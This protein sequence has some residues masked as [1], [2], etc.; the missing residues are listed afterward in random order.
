MWTCDLKVVRVDGVTAATDDARPSADIDAVADLILHL[1]LVPVRQ[2]D[3]PSP[4]LVLVGDHQLIENRK[5]LR[6]PSQ[7]DRMVRF[8]HTRPSLA[9]SF[10][11]SLDGVVQYAP[12]PAGRSY[13]TGST[14]LPDD[15]GKYA[16]IS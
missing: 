14:H 15:S 11:L 6:R 13:R 7:H 4:G 5:D 16:R 1:H 10:H 2:D 8:E 3:D 9:Q 12:Q